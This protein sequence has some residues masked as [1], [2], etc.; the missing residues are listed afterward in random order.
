MAKVDVPDVTFSR[1]VEIPPAKVLVPWPAP[2]V[3][4]AAKVEVAVVEVLVKYDP[5]MLLPNMSPATESFW[6]GDVV[7][8]PRFPLLF[9]IPLPG[10]YALP[11]TVSAVVDAY[12]KRDVDDAISPFV[13][14]IGVDVEF[15]AAP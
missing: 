3:I 12:T 9:Q 8:M 14:Q 2:T 13:N 7:P 15:A 6:P 4:A 5:M 10:K 11:E 1:V